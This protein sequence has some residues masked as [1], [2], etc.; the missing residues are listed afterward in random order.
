MTDTRRALCW[1]LVVALFT[2]AALIAT[3]PAPDAVDPPPLLVTTPSTTP[4][5][6]YEETP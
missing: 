4:P 6:I 5:V 3:A 1:L 2:I